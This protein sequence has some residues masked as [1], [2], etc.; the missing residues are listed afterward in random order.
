MKSNLLKFNWNS[1]FVNFYKQIH[2]L[3]SNKTITV[4]SSCTTEHLHKQQQELLWKKNLAMWKSRA[5]K[6]FYNYCW[7]KLGLRIHGSSNCFLYSNLPLLITVNNQF[8]RARRT[9]FISILK[10]N[11]HGY[12]PQQL[13][14]LC[15]FFMIQLEVSI[16]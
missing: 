16:E 2:F 6:H 3:I 12:L 8:S 13:Q 5:K 11:V 15:L 14:F 1:T 10:L 9:Y 4:L 7:S